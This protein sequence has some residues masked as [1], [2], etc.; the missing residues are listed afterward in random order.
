[1]RRECRECFPNHRLQKHI[2]L[3]FST[4][5]VRPLPFSNLMCS[6]T[7]YMNACI[8]TQALT[9]TY[10]AICISISCSNVL[11]NVSMKLHGTIPLIFFYY[12]PNNFCTNKYAS[13]CL[14]HQYIVHVSVWVY[15]AIL[16]LYPQGKFKINHHKREIV[17][18]AKCRHHKIWCYTSMSRCWEV[19]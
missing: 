16:I 6:S 14:L 17:G 15:F 19:Y 9:W 12:G 4:F 5:S 3:P 8:Y 1:M 18:V 2:H 10:T 13:R 11:A 7:T